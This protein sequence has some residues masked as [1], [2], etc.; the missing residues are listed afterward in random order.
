MKLLFMHNAIPEYRIPWFKK[1]SEQCD[2][3]FLFTN[4]KIIKR[5]Y[6][7]DTDLSDIANLNYGL[8][9]S[10]IHAVKNIGRL[11]RK[12]NEFDFIM[13]PPCDSPFEF[14]ICYMVSLEAKKNQIPFSYFWEK[15]EAPK[16]KQ[17]LKRKLINLYGKTMA[18]I[19]FKKADLIFCGSTSSRKYFEERGV[20]KDKLVVIPDAST[21]PVCGFVDIK[22][23]YNIPKDKILI[24]FFGRLL[25][26]KGVYSLVKAFANID[27]KS[28]HLLIAGDGQDRERTEN[29]VK[30]NGMKNITF[31]GWVHPAERYNY[32]HQC[33]MFVFQGNFYHGRTDVWGL[34]VVE[35]VE[36]GKP[37]ISTTAIGSAIDLIV[38]GEN[39]F[40]LD[41]TLDEE[42][43]IN[44][45]SCCIERISKEGI[46]EKAA[47]YNASLYKKYS[48]DAM[49]D[50]FF[51]GI[52]SCMAKKKS[53]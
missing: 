41:A 23:L 4:Q 30:A 25:F 21:T 9:G 44:E 46:F 36:N 49:T 37:I 2:V 6:H 17:D 19:I 27:S 10:G 33:D 40:L 52:T 29:F 48:F 20:A 28:Y 14:L 38:D 31:A 15:W 8:V 42:S 35:A 43:F 13:L 24:L 45:L 51:K 53:G 32:F 12:I 1:I 47:R 34:T 5:Q 26:Q 22:N 7:F 11:I 18:G 3:Y 16:E 39:G 50:V